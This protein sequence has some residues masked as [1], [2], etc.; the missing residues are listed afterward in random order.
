MS[1]SANYNNVVGRKPYRPFSSYI[2]PEFAIDPNALKSFTPLDENIDLQWGGKSY[3]SDKFNMYYDYFFSGEDV[4]VYIDG[5]FDAGYE[6][7]IASFSFSIRQEKSPI[8]GFWSYNFDAV[9]TG[10]R[11][12]Q[13]RICY[14]H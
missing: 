3:D 14:L 10:T 4:K 13:R 7:D 1:S 12:I 11:I 5:L 2:P 8:Y 9:L 6:L